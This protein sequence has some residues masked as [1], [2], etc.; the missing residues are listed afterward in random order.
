MNLTACS[1]Q[2]EA[3]LSIQ[4]IPLQTVQVQLPKSPRIINEKWQQCGVSFC[5]SSSDVDKT[6]RNKI[7]IIRWMKEAKS[8]IKYY[9][10]SA[11]DEQVK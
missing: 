8:V 11:K 9:E 3:P 5:M 1:K 7:E 6:L 2:I 10:Q 4:T